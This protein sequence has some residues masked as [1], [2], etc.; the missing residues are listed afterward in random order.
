MTG[1]ELEVL[2]IVTTLF[3]V[4]T[5]TLI[6]LRMF[7]TYRAKRFENPGPEQVQRLVETMEAL[8]QDVADTRA[9]LSDLHERVDFAERLLT[10]AR[11][12]GR[13]DAGS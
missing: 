11:D 9:E 13:L 7:L 8:R 1:A 10:K 6:G 5:F 3:G 12:G 4:G 2:A